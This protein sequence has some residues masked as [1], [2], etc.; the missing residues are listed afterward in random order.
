MVVQYENPQN[1]V[2]FFSKLNLSGIK[3]ILIKN[4]CDELPSK[5]V[6]GKDIDILVDLS[7][8]A[9][10]HSFMKEYGRQIIHPYSKQNGWNT[11]YELPEFEMWRLFNGEE[12]YIDVT[13]KL[14]CKSLMPMLWIPLDKS[15]NEYLWNNKEYNKEKDYWELDKNTQFVYYI[16]RCVFDKKVF[17]EKYIN[18]IELSKNDIDREIVLDFFDKIFFKFTPELMELIIE[19]KYDEI[20][21]RYIAYNNY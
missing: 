8:K 10:F 7:D 4:I 5:L 17:S 12:L 9:L 21:H 2:D 19:A 14:C 20:I 18:M 11:I 16:V 15:I 6:V 13:Y 1:I 3:Y